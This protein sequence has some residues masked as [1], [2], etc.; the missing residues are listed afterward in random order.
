MTELGVLKYYLILNI[1]LGIFSVIFL[2]SYQYYYWTKKKSHQKVLITKLFYLVNGGLGLA[3]LFA[4]TD[5]I[6]ILISANLTF[7]H[8]YFPNW[9]YPG[10]LVFY[11]IFLTASFISLLWAICAIFFF[12]KKIILFLT[13]TTLSTMF[14]IFPVNQEAIKVTTFA[15]TTLFEVNEI[16]LQYRSK[17][18]LTAGLIT[19]YDLKPKIND[20]ENFNNN[21]KILNK[22]K[23][24]T[25]IAAT[26]FA[27]SSAFGT[28]YWQV[29]FQ[30]W[31]NFGLFLLKLVATLMITYIFVS[32]IVHFFP[33]EWIF[34]SYDGK[35]Y[36]LKTK[37]LV[38]V[39]TIFLIIFAVIEIIAL[40]FN[41]IVNLR[42]KN[43]VMTSF[44][45]GQ[46]IGWIVSLSLLLYF[47]TSIFLL[48]DY[49]NA[50][51]ITPTLP[52]PV[53]VAKLLFWINEDY[54]LGMGLI[55]LSLLIV[56]IIT[57]ALTIWNYHWEKG[58][59]KLYRKFNI[60]LPT[61]VIKNLFKPLER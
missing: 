47:F 6:L 21:W 41:L 43:I 59:I 25:K 7:V 20:N 33:K 38:F 10:R 19:Y 13:P 28:L 3:F 40:S 60:S 50:K 58:T 49:L 57:L 61:L 29:F 8:N 5:L 22:Q 53:I 18:K 14:T 56:N 17:N 4:L 34:Y 12:D 36:L 2:V 48:V 24:T 44:I 42:T 35:N 27:N 45:I 52:A 46:I 39:L 16:N 55:I 23:Y 15:T 32:G 1:L 9:N 11:T 51:N 54:I 31:I 37:N 30:K 26:I